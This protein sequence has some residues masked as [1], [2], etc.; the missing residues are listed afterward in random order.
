[1]ILHEKEFKAPAVKGNRNLIDYFPTQIRA[2]LDEGDIPIRF[3]LTSTKGDEYAYEVGVLTGQKETRFRTDPAIFQF[4]QRKV[5]NTESF[6]IALVVP[7]GIGAEIGGHD[8]DAGPLTRLLAPLC[9][10]LITHPNVV[11]A[12]DINELPPNGIYVEGS[13][14]SRFLLGSIGLQPV[15]SNRVLVVID[16]HKEQIFIN[17]AINAVSAARAA[18]GLQCPTVI[19]LDPP[20]ELTSQ[21]SASGRAVGRIDGFHALTEVLDEYRDQYDAV[22]LASVIYVPYSYHMDYFEKRG[23][24]VNPWG[25]VEAM[26]THAISEY[27]NVP[28]AHAPMFE[29]EEIANMDPGI[30]DPRMAAEAVSLTF[31]QSVLKGLQKSPR[32]ITDEEAMKHSA[33]LT[34]EDVSALVI[35]DGCIG[36]PTL[37]ALEQGIPVI[38][39]R[40]NRNIMRNDLTALPWSTGQLHIV[41]NY[42]EATGV[43]AAMKAGIAPES[44]RR[45]LAD[46]A[47]EVRTQEGIEVIQQDDVE[48]SI[49]VEAE[50]TKLES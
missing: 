21:Y 14:L 28:T 6:N 42:W 37:A 17:A 45:P 4:R 39:V 44:V 13:V 34:A 19:Q 46:T 27:Y 8:G 47:T 1:M 9:D 49:S 40:E 16:A 5:E 11:N 18:Y 32:I 30:V 43:L 31:L 3:A 29:N 36:L 2:Q 35:P 15:R 26:L 48:K 20:I 7:T 25:G 24:M 22:A 12:S 33:V 10:G 38:A 23:E 41:E 50:I